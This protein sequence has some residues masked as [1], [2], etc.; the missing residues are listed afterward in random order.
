MSANTSSFY[1]LHDTTIEPNLPFTYPFYYSPHVEI[2]KIAALLQEALMNYQNI[3]EFAIAVNQKMF[4]VLIVKDSKGRTGYLIAISGINP[5]IEKY[6]RIVPSIVSLEQKDGFFKKEEAFI[7]RVNQLIKDIDNSRVYLKKKRLLK[8]MKEQN[9]RFIIDAQ[10]RKTEEK[11][12]RAKQREDSY[13]LSLENQKSIEAEL[14]RQSQQMKRWY[15]DQKR[16]RGNSEKELIRELEQ[17]TNLL[18]ALK[19]IRKQSSRQL[20]NKIFQ[21]YQLLNGEGVSK[22]MMEVFYEYNEELPPAGAGDCAA[23][24]L[25]Q[26]AFQH[27]LI[28]LAMGEFWW[29]PNHQDELRKHQQFYPACKSKCYP[30]LSYM[31]QGLRVEK[32]Q[33]ETIAKQSYQLETMYED[34]YILIVNKPSGLLSVPGKE[35]ENSVYS[36]IHKRN[37]EFTGPL[38]VHRL[39]MSTSGLLIMAKDMETYKRVQKLFLQKKIQKRYIALIKGELKQE[40]G[41][42][43][44]PL[45]VDLD[46]RPLQMVCQQ[47]GKEAHTKWEKISY[48]KGQTKIALYPITG[49][50]HQLRVHCAHKLGLN[51][52]IVGDDLYGEVSKQR[53]C[54]HAEK[55]IFQHPYS[56][57]VMQIT[58]SLPF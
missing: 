57:E 43:H 28:P 54:L 38:L 27:N 20:Q 16:E 41:E 31:T 44:L 40:K 15:K 33:V 3:E 12:K 52:P 56:A 48:N 13:K 7:T 14:Q 8:T 5:N 4:G 45:R 1:E 22:C 49:R 23:P 39:D 9:E 50:T 19:K 21:K 6:I 47:Y 24:K 26:Y 58:S 11:T 53:L 35:I 42:I 34:D 32:N 10:K 46:N 36:I 29:D 51:A 37:P 55:I 25:L 30:I 2:K 17:Y 18:E